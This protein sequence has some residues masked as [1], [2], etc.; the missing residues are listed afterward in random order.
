M[1][2]AE[3]KRSRE[4]FDAALERPAEERRAFLQHACGEDHALLDS[5]LRLLQFVDEGE[6]EMDVQPG[7]GLRRADRPP[8]VSSRSSQPTIATVGALAPDF[9]LECVSSDTGKTSVVSLSEYRGD[10]LLLVFYPRDFS[11]VC[12]TELT[13]LSRRMEEFRSSGAD[14]LALSVDSIETHKRWLRTPRGHGGLGG[15]RFP[16][17]SDPDGAVSRAYGVYLD[18]LHVAL[19]GLF[20]ID[21]NGVIQYNAVHNHSVGRRTDEVMR[22][23]SALQTGGLCPED[24]TPGLAAID[25]LQVLHAGSIVSHYEIESCIGAGSFGCVF[26]ARDTSLERTVALKIIPPDSPATA[27]TVLDEARAAAALNHVNICTVFAVDDSE[28]IPFIAMEYVD[29]MSLRDLMDEAPL[30]VPRVAEIGGQIAEGMSAAHAMGIAHG[31]L[32]PANVMVRDDG[33]VKI[34]DF[35]LARP[36]QQLVDADATASCGPCQPGSICG[37]PAYMSPEQTE[38]KRATPA[39]DVFSLGI[40]LYELLT[41]ERAYAGETISEL[42]SQVKEIE[43]QRYA[44]TTPQPFSGIFGRAL[45]RDPNARDIIMA[46][47]SA[48]LNAGQ[49]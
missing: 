32:K 24:W 33:V 1:R 8:G 5:V 12:P 44:A 11:L 13:G 29:G 40:M 18:T 41:G 10:W 28:G 22:V 38:G 48:A 16:L 4:L 7:P 17:A 9:Q 19:R 26:R 2:A 20:I 34:L 49:V 25:P 15:L 6:D 23:L 36:P 47:I 37:T 30:P 14:I 43:P 3:H 31:D 45:H 46:D 27:A 35:G 21:P 42:L 39:S